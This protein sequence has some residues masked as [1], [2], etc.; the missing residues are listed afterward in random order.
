[1]FE[2]YTKKEGK[3][4]GYSLGIDCSGFVFKSYKADEQLLFSGLSLNTGSIGQLSVFRNAQVSGKAFVHKNFSK[5]SKGDF[6]YKPGHVMIASGRIKVDKNGKVIAFQTLEA[7]DTEHGSIIKWRNVDESYT[8]GHPFRKT[9]I[10]TK[11][12]DVIDDITKLT[13]KKT[14]DLNGEE[15]TEKNLEQEVVK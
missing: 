5:I 2:K 9:D 11:E 3:L 1:M 13:T 12:I 7:N 8:I 6:I 15:R 14:V 10:T 4:N